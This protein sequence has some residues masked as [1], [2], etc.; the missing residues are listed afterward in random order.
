LTNNIKAYRTKTDFLQCVDFYS[1]TNIYPT[2]NGLITVYNAGEIT[3][4]DSNTFQHSGTNITNFKGLMTMF[5]GTKYRPS[6]VVYAEFQCNDAY[7]LT[8][9]VKTV[10]ENGGVVQVDGGSFGNPSTLTKKIGYY[11]GITTITRKML[12]DFG[13]VSGKNFIIKNVRFSMAQ[14]DDSIKRSP[15]MIEELYTNLNAKL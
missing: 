6:I 3:F 8:A 1:G 5:N 14:F 4:P 7:A 9:T 13:A 12:V 15:N 2:Y 10:D 11:N